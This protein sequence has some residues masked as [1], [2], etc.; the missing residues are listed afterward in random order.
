[1]SMSISDHRNS[2]ALDIL[3]ALDQIFSELRNVLEGIS[4]I[5]ELSPKTLDLLMSF[6][7]RLSA[8]IITE[9]ILPYISQVR[10]LDAR[11]LIKT[12]RTFGAAQ[13][14]FK[15]TNKNI[16]QYFHDFPGIIPII[17]GFI[18][19]SKENETTSLGMRLYFINL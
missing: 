14:H 6:G 8:F 18:G 19:S 1:M 9:A 13:V 15:Q 12:D 11:D 2:F 7:E 17:T 4:L 5:K 3:T 16:S 10:F